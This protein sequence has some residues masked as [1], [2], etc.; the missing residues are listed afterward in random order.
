MLVFIED[1]VPAF[2]KIDEVRVQQVIN[3]L[4][5]NAIKFTESGSITLNVSLKSDQL[6]FRITDTGIGIPLSDQDKIFEN[7]E[8][9]NSSMNSGKNGTGLGLAISSKLIQL[10]GGE[11]GVESEPGKGSCFW[12]TI[13]FV[14]GKKEKTQ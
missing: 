13:D 10:M 12:F 1:H 2:V 11:I 5:S 7:F 6:L 4:L 9:V 14:V 3:N 8:Q